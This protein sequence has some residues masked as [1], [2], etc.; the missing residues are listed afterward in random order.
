LKVHG[1]VYN[2]PAPGDVAPG[3]TFSVELPDDEP[4]IATPC[5]QPLAAQPLAA[6]P[7]A[8]G[9]AMQV[10]VPAGVVAGQTLAVQ[11]PGGQRLH[12]VVPPGLSAGQAFTVHMPSPAHA[13]APVASPVVVEAQYAPTAAPGGKSANPF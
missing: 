8:A 1:C 4:Q 2:I 3:A 5:A 10:V 6:Q 13:A 11:G 7:Y 12:A 9:Q